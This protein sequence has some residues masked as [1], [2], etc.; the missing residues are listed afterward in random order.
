MHRKSLCIVM[1]LSGAMTFSASGARE[2]VTLRD[3]WE[4]THGRPQAT[5]TPWQG[6]GAPPPRRGPLR[7][8]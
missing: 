3:G 1:A 8:V 4:F 6:R 7:A 2:N 5:G